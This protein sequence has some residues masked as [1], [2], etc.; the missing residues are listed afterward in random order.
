MRIIE[1]AACTCLLTIVVLV[2]DTPAQ[3]ETLSVSSDGTLADKDCFLGTGYNW[4]NHLGNTVSGNGRFIAFSTLASNL[5]PDDTN[6]TADIFVRDRISGTTRRISVS[7]SGAQS[8]GWSSQVSIS[9]DGRLVAFSSYGSNLVPGDSYGTLEVFVHDRQTGTT[10]LVSVGSRGEKANDACSDPFLSADGRFVAFGSRATNLVSSDTNDS[11]DIFLHDRQTGITERV[12]VNS[13]EEEANKESNL[14]T[15]SADGSRVAFTSQASNLWP[16]FYYGRNIFVRDRLA[17]ETTCVS[18]DVTGKPGGEASDGVIS[19]DG[20]VVVFQSNDQDL[21]PIDTNFVEDAFL[22]DLAANTTEM[23]SV[24]SD[25]SQGNDGSGYHLSLSTDGSSVVFSSASANL[26][27][28]PDG[29]LDVF[30]RDRTRGI[31]MNLSDNLPTAKQASG[32]GMSADGGFV[33]FA[34]SDYV[35]ESPPVDQVFGRE[36][37]FVGF[38]TFGVGLAGS[39]G[40]VPQLDGSDG[41]CFGSYTLHVWNGLGRATLYLWVGLG[42]GDFPFSGGRFYIDLSRPWAFLTLTLGGPAGVPGAGSLDLPGADISD[43]R[44]I[45]FYLQGTIVDPGAI[46]GMA[47]TNGLIMDL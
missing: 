43:F 30:L 36:I 8:D 5:V 12:S 1:I 6:G 26:D 46:Q 45:D 35:Y 18:L 20:S 2:C 9:G 42:S 33:A 28:D 19:K 27:G 16:G 47:L 13:S 32:C 17:G 24:A 38:E 31:T 23:I 3:V 22:R 41:E 40:I 44:G 15:V 25:G 29:F 14:P 7:T 21:V 10:T 37:C 11:G 4:N 39:G 34:S